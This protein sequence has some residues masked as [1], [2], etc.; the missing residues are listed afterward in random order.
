MSIPIE[1]RRGHEQQRKHRQ[2]TQ[3]AFLV[4]W[5]WFAEQIGLIQQLRA[6]SPQ[7]KALSSHASDLG[8]GISGGHP[9]WAAALAGDQPDSSS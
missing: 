9:G 4:A 1:A 5:G 7:A 6:V 3:H 8:V 2:D